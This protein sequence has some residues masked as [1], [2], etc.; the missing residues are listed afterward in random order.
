[1][2]RDE[3][4]PPLGRGDSARIKGAIDAGRTRDKVPGFDAA[5]ETDEES[6]GDTLSQDFGPRTSA[7]PRQ[8]QRRR[9][10]RAT[11]GRPI[12]HKT[13][14][15][16]RSFRTDLDYSASSAAGNSPKSLPHSDIAAAIRPASTNPAPRA[17]A[18]PCHAGSPQRS[19]RRRQRFRWGLVLCQRG[20]MSEQVVARVDRDAQGTESSQT[21]RWRELDWNFRFRDALSIAN[22]AAPV[23]R[24]IRR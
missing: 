24:L 17:H 3:R 18:R 20:E 2:S 10:P 1:V 7:E 21:L 14:W 5:L 4:R 23:A 13:G 19:A 15:F 12:A 16:G 11:T 22:G 6:A 8:P 9:I